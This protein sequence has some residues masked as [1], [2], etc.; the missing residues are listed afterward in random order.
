MLLSEHLRQRGI[1]WRTVKALSVRQPYA[2][3]I[4]YGEKT[5]EWRSK[6]FAYRGPLVIC[7]SKTVRVTMRNGI[8]LPVGVAL[9]VVDMVDCHPMRPADL[10]AACCEDWTGPVKG[11]AWRLVDPHEVEPVP[12]KGIVAPWPWAQRGGPDLT[13]CPGWHAEHIL[14][15]LD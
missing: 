13:L 10:A 4:V 8:D 5:V 12:V 9:G 11:F 15:G 1:D 14:R 7:A 6:T 3:Q 2:S